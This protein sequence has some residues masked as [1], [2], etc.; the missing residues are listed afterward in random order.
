MWLRRCGHT[1]AQPRRG[2][3]PFTTRTWSCSFPRKRRPEAR[4]PRCGLTLG[5]LGVCPGF[6]LRSQ[7]E[8]MWGHV[9]HTTV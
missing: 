3:G 4:K 1:E 5:A 2:P 9:S 7:E 6:S 8:K